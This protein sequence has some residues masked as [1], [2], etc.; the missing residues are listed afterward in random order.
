MPPDL[1]PTADLLNQELAPI[2]ERALQR[3]RALLP[4]EF[5]VAL[6]VSRDQPRV[7]ALSQ[8]LED[9]LFSACV[10]AWQ[11]MA[12]LATQVVVES[13]EVVLDDVVLS[14]DAE[15][16]Q[17]GLPPRR[18]VRLVI[19]DSRRT[20][21][22]PL[23]CLM[24]PPAVVD[25][26]PASARRLSLTQ[27]HEVV[28]RHRGTINVSAKA[29]LGT[30]FDIYLPTVM[31]LDVPVVSDSGTDI[32]HVLY[33]DDYEAMRE[34]VSESLPDAGFRVSCFENGKDALLFLQSNWFGCDAVVSDYK[35]MD[36]SG[37]ELL[38]QIRRLHPGIPVIII[39]GY[40]DEAL[41]SMAHAQ[42]A[43]LV[44][45]K[46]DDLNELCQALRQVLVTVPKP[47]AGRY[48]DWASL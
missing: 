9:V 11:S 46:T 5:D 30:A 7:R 42:G 25:D 16:L 15:I 38:K 39:S 32:K 19:S 2:L 3:F 48:T 23:H 35:L 14:P 27:M 41:R 31:P 47:A 4:A 37:I 21:V 10:V 18:Y 13:M 34:L 8:P 28:A 22:G 24:P 40:L 44:V 36:L 33:V 6:D 29:S 1:R 26:Q 17:G 45:S 12:G 20:E 43:A